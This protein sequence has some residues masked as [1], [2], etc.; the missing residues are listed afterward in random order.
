MKKL[1]C[2]L[3]EQF[4]ENEILR[5]LYRASREEEE[6]IMKIVRECKEKV[7]ITLIDVGMVIKL[8]ETDRL[9]FINFIKS[10]I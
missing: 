8:K 10:V 2:L 9:N 6:R 3:T 5:K 1:E 4:M 7:K